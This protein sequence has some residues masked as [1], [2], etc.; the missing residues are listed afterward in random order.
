MSANVVA[1]GVVPVLVWL[2]MLAALALACPAAA[3]VVVAIVAAGL[4]LARSGRTAR[5]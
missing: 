4:I 1:H 2:V 5:R 3:G